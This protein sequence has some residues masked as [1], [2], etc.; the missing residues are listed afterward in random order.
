MKKYNH[1]VIEKKWQDRWDKSEI[2]NA[3][4]LSKKPKYYYLIEFPYPSGAGLHVGHLRSHIAI[5]IVARKKRMNGFNVMYPIGWDAFGLPTENFAIKTKTHPKI[6]TKDNIKNFTRQIKSYGPSFDWSREINTTDPKYYKWTQWIFLKLFNSFYDERSDK[7][8]PIEELKI[9]KNLN[10]NEKREY[11]DDQRMAYEKEMAINWCP[12]CK[13]GLANEEVV[14]DACERCGTSA[15]KKTM[16]QWMLRITKYAD[17]LIRDL[18]AVD[19]LDKIKTQQVNWIGRSEGA[20][21]EFAVIASEVKQSRN[22]TNSVDSNGINT[23]PTPSQEGNLSPLAPRNDNAIEVFTTRPD[24]LFGCTYMVLSPEHK[25]IEELQPEIKN[26]EEVEKYIQKAVNKSDLD[27]TDL[28]KE[29]TGVELKGIKAINPGNGEK[30]S[31]WIAD[32]VLASYGT[33]AIMA[34]P[35]HDKRD[36]EFA[37]KY[38]LPIKQVIAPY[39]L[40][41]N[42]PPQK[43]KEDTIREVVHVIL[44]NKK[45]EVLTLNLKGKEWGNNKPKTLVI[46]GIEEGET[47]EVT[48]LREIREETGYLD[49]DVIKIHPIEFHAEF[50]AAHKNVNRYVKTIGVICKLTSDRKEIVTENEK[51]LHDIVW[52]KRNILSNSVTIPDDIF[53]AKTYNNID[54]YTDPGILINSKHFN[55][56]NSVDAKKKITK[57]LFEKKL[58]R[59][60]VNYKLRDWIFSRQ[61]YWGEPIPIVKCKNCALKKMKI[62][63]ELNFRTKKVWNEIIKNEKKIETRALNPEEKEGYFGDIK[64]GDIVKFN[65]KL[66]EEFEIVKINKVYNFQN[67]K[68]LFGSKELLKKIIPNVAITKLSQLEKTYSFTKDYLDRIEKN[69]LIGWEFEK[70]NVTENISLLK[71]D[72]PLELPDVK[73]YEPTE[74][75]ESPLAKIDKWVDVKCPKCGCDAKRETDTMPNWA[76]SSWYFLRYTDFDNEKEFASKKNLEKWMPVDLYNGGMEHT[77]LHLLYSRFWHKFLYD[78]NYVQNTEP[79]KM[80]R[81]HGMI[82]AED[83]QKMSKSRGNTVNPDEIINKYGADTIRLYEMFMGPYGDAIPWSTNSLIGMNRFLERVWT[84]QSKVGTQNLVFSSKEKRAQNLAPLQNDK[85]QTILVAT[86]NQGKLKEFKDHLKD[87]D[88]ISL[89]DI[90]EKIQEPEEN[91]KTFA[92]N[93]LIKAEYYAKKTGYLTIADDSGLC[94]NALGGRPGVFSSR[95]AEGDDKKGCEKLIKEL[96][97]KTDR[98]AYYKSVI[99]LYNPEN[100]EYDQFDGKCEGEILDSLK[101]NKSFGYAPVFMTKGLNRSNAECSSEER[102]KYNHRKQAVDKLIDHLKKRTQNFASLQNENIEPLLHKTIK[103]VT[104][105]ID[106]LKFNTAISSLMILANEMEKEKEISLIHYS[107]FLILL[108][109]FA[110]HITEELWELFEEKES[111]HLQ[112]WPK[113]NPELIKEK[114]IQLVIQINGKLRDQ[115]KVSADISEDEA[116]KIALESE[117]VQKWIEGKEIRKIIFVKGKLVNVVVQ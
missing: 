103:K 88:I 67:L 92:E 9:P 82:L 95:Y 11:I 111:I 60:A 41:E 69:G 98:S 16:K 110:P 42:N 81:S 47:P 8:R 109:P 48:A 29:K 43:G 96:E 85:L 83:G 18:E 68:E 63:M 66:T 71:K 40:D 61:H 56:L 58:G 97:N 4:N 13:T 112:E 108:S 27:R 46:G 49:V 79:Y 28:A 31:I 5:D 116:K 91:G 89:K 15:E 105:D 107:Q 51:Q 55:A 101:G 65:N 77:T 32:Y 52:V 37:K 21:V 39:K 115:V 36:F 30:I 54:F 22:D 44:E 57:W 113:Y 94:V 50:F 99:T 114:E 73:K 74:T 23:L 86:N 34:V 24:T 78:L 12:S 84:M 53:L 72:L 100:N 87:F 64:I 3:K 20:E 1:K 70:I 26:L 6:V 10:E 14:N 35:A 59:K 2:Y 19:Y 80:R 90:N 25:L 75:G 45:G 106:N 17:R 38:K 62:K 102:Y 104:E 76:G 93:S 7:A 33:G 117:K